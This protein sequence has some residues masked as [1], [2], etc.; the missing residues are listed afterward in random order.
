MSEYLKKS[1]GAIFLLTTVLILGSCQDPEDVPAP[2]NNPP[3]ASPN[4]PINTWIQDVM[5]EVYFWLE[6]MRQP[7]AKESDPE[8]YFEAL[9]NRP[10]DRFSEIFPDARELENS[11]QGVNREAGYEILL[12][13]A[14]NENEDVLAFVAYIK[15]GS[16]AQSAG[17]KRGDVITQINDQ[18]LTLSN[19]Q[20]VLRQRSQNHSVNFFRFNPSTGNYQPQPQLNLETVVLAENPNFMDTV[21]TI[22]DKK[23]GYAVYHF[24][25]PGVDGDNRYD[26]Q[27]D[28]IFGRFKA[29]GI[30][31]LI[32]DLRYNGGGA[33]SSSVNLASLIAPNVTSEDLFS[34][35]KYNSFLSQ[36]PQIQALENRFFTSKAE[37]LGNILEGNR[38]H[39]ITSGRTASA[40]EI[41]INGLKPFMDVYLIG[42][43]TFGKNVGSILIDDEQNPNNNYGLLPIVSMIFNSAG[44]SDF[45]NGF[46]P[47]VE[48]NEL[49][50]P[51]LLPFG[52]TDEYL[53]SLAIQQI[54]GT[55]ARLNL[56]ERMDIGSS[57]EDKIRFG[58]I[59][60]DQLPIK[61]LKEY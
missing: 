41:I 54:T 43:T 38:I 36:F 42:G 51:V 48:A 5:D 14:S 50:Q 59:L 57:F 45:L 60:E 12:A 32:L 1:K 26:N 61:T 28:E 9:L 35:T 22:N 46:R 13:R 3:T 27:M 56:V 23:I 53:L 7:I 2:D 19:F 21:F 39:I 10:T 17:L 52:D 8:D 44:N 15:K 58:K 18:T 11:L 24:F 33:L 55:S 30:N 25:A 4:V 37:N 16:P 31:H 20:N 47:N 6:E 34:R 40:S 49:S 29:E